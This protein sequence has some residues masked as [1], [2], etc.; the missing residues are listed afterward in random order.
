MMSVQAPLRTM[1]PLLEMFTQAPWVQ[2]SLTALMLP[3]SEV[4]TFC[5]G[6]GMFPTIKMTPENSTTVIARIRIVPTTSE[7]PSLLQ[8]R[9]LSKCLLIGITPCYPY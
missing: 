7:T 2:S 3:C 9:L 6:V 4:F 5:S 1:P 8:T